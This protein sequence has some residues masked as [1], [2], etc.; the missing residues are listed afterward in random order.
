MIYFDAAATTF[1]KPPAVAAAMQEA[2]RTM[3]S[4]GRGGHPAAMR[5]ADT[6]FQC[7]SELA[8]LFGAKQP[9]QA[10]FTMN[11]THA[12]NIVIKG[13]LNE[14]TTVS[15]LGEEKMVIINN[16]DLLKPAYK[17][18]DIITKFINYFKSYV[19]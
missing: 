1:Q 18:S 16:P 2:L 9:E 13:I 3:A 6:A 11:A 7:R 12:L 17:N 14:I 15:L 4:P 5:A 8:E 19:Y 10:V